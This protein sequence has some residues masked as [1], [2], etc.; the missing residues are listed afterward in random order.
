M[1]KTQNNALFSS[2]DLIKAQSF[3]RFESLS[4]RGIFVLFVFEEVFGNRDLREL[5]FSSMLFFDEIFTFLCPNATIFE[6]VLS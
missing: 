5:L 2:Q 3:F 1:G 4:G 6:S